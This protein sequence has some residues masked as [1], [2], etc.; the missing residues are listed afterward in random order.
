MNLTYRGI[1][2]HKSQTIEPLTLNS[3]YK[4]R[5]INYCQQKPLIHHSKTPLTYRGIS[6]NQ[7]GIELAKA[8]IQKTSLK[9]KTVPGC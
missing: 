5:G 7:D 1:S 9:L 2:Y 3:T 6:Y 8:S 4:Y